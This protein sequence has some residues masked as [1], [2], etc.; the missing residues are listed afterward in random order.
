MANKKSPSKCV[1]SMGEKITRTQYS[2][3]V[4]GV[5][6][7]NACIHLINDI[8]N[9]TGMNPKFTL[10]TIAEAFDMKVVHNKKPTMRASVSEATA[11]EGETED[12]GD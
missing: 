4:S 11:K 1:I 2:G 12:E 3:K 5:N 7:L 6:L 8:E 9:T 10:G